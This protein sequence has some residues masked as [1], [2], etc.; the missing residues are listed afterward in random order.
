MRQMLSSAARTIAVVLAMS[1]LGCSVLV[2]P[3]LNRLPR[4][5]A[6]RADG[7]ADGN[8]MSD[9]GPT[10][11]RVDV[12][13]P[14]TDTLIPPDA[15]DVVVTPD[16][17]RMCMGSCDDGIPC[18]I[19]GCNTMIGMCEH[20]ADNTRCSGNTVCDLRMGCITRPCMTMM[21][22]DDGDRCNGTETCMGGSCR[23]GTRLVC[24]DGMFCNG[25]ETCVAATGCQPGTPPTCADGTPCTTDRCDPAANIC[26]NLPVDADGDMVPAAM[27][28]GIRCAAGTD[29]ND[30]NPMIRPGATEICNMMDDNCNGMT[31][32]GLACGAPPND[33]CTSA[34]AITLTTS[35]VAVTV[36]GTNRG[37]TNSLNSSCGQSDGPDV[38]YAIT[39]PA[40]MDLTVETT[41]GGGGIDPV[42]VFADAC[43]M[44]TV[45]A[46][47]N[48]DARSGNLD[49]RMWFRP[50]GPSGVLTRTILVAV[51]SYS[52][53]S[54]GPFTL[55]AVANAPSSAATCGAA[56]DVH[57]GGTVVGYAV[58]RP[59]MQ[60]GSCLMLTPNPAEEVY[61][62]SGTNGNVDVS[63]AS[64][65]FIPNVY[66]RSTDCNSGAQL[67]CQNGNPATANYTHATGMARSYIFVDN[68][69]MVTIGPGRY[70]LTI[71][72]P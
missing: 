56:F 48:D 14:P 40:N 8:M 67:R 51:D 22:C 68:M 15:R 46:A 44:P 11:G 69:P 3:D 28:G 20:R 52:S 47:C 30:M 2:N 12:V 7:S 35:G 39:Y 6:A 58:M 34:A 45:P 29:C 18:T 42:L 19:D 72:S 25:V 26:R 5:D 23:A 33:Q 64:R 59:G 63:A 61:S 16:V 24:D 27:V 4:G 1:G 50:P 31:D 57:P 71:R 36:T 17:L 62:Y 66:V 43:G 60:Q 10:D 9:T 21:D 41:T 38:W 49:A 32:E 13:M 54:S 37:A 70:T 53:G 65:A 55:R